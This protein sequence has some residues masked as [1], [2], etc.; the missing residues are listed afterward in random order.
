MTQDKMVIFHAECIDGFTAAWAAW[1]ALGESALYVPA[2]HGDQPPYSVGG[3]DVYIVDFSFPRETL[4]RL[5]AEA[6]SLLVL[7]HHKTAQADLEGLDFCQFDMKRSGAGMTWDY[8]R[9]TV[10]HAPRPWLVD[11]VEDRDLWKWELDRSRDVS[12]Y[13]GVQERDTFAQWDAMLHLPVEKAMEA[14]REI[15]RG[16]ERYV[17]DMTKEVRW[18]TVDGH[19]V[20]VVNAPYINISEVLNALVSKYKPPFAVGWQ[21]QA[22]GS[23]NYSLRSHDEGV[24]VSA[25]AKA[26]GGGGHRNAAGFRAD[27]QLW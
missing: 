9:D 25:V 1:K 10:H 18:A 2:K 4:L 21:Q 13:I 11:Y 17:R 12:A 20:P 15:Q 19:E 5:K 16:V 7:D 27:K 22:N 14:G 26:H 3:M 8:F 24:D 23:Y 6:K